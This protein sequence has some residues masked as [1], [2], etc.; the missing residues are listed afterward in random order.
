MKK[1]LY[2][3]TNVF[4]ALVIAMVFVPQVEASGDIQIIKDGQPIVVADDSQPFIENGRTFVPLRL[5]GELYACDV[6]WMAESEYGSGTVFVSRTNSNGTVDSYVFLLGVYHYLIAGANGD[7][8]GAGITEIPIDAPP[9]IV[10]SRMFVPLRAMGELFGTVEWEEESRSV[11]L[12][13]SGSLTPKTD[14]IQQPGGD[15]VPDIG[16]GSTSPYAYMT[17]SMQKQLDAFGPL[18]SVKTLLMDPVFSGQTLFDAVSALPL[19]ESYYNEKY[20]FHV[21]KPSTW[22]PAKTSEIGDGAIIYDKDG[23]DIRAYGLRSMGQ[24]SEDYF[25][26][27]HRGENAIYLGMIGNYPCYI[28]NSGDNVKTWYL[29]DTV[30]EQ[31]VAFY[32]KTG[33]AH[34]LPYGNRFEED[35]AYVEMLAEEVFWSYVEAH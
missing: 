25:A 10:N 3:L 14:P 35:L 24:Q 2:T 28:I 11:L 33:T 15:I 18:D 20:I 29:F 31:A 23:W 32:V 26:E 8:L 12:G 6:D 5:I 22:G 34:L 17:K 19:S 1:V 30:N 7:A 9:R 21:I 27:F 13:T 16:G 4:L